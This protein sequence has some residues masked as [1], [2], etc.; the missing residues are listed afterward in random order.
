[1]KKGALIN[2]INWKL[3]KYLFWLGPMLVIMG[4]T[5]GAVIGSWGVVPSGLVLAGIAVIVA[6]LL[7]ESS[8]QPGFWR[9]RSTQVSTNAL[10]AT[11]AMLIILAMV[12]VLAVRYSA[13]LDLTENQIFTLAPQTQEVVQSLKQPVK[14]WIFSPTPNPL[15]KELLENYRRQNQQFSYE[16][17]DPQAKPGVAEKFEVQSIGEIYLEA[18]NNRKFVQTLN[19]QEQLSERK[20]TN[21]IAQV[22]NNQPEKVYFLQGH[23]ERSLDAGQ[24]AMSQAIAA[25][26]EENYTPEPLNLAQAL[27]VPEDAKV[28][29]MASP[30]RPLL[31]RERE[32]LEAYLQRQSGLLLL[33]DPQTD[34]QLNDLLSSWGVQLSDRLVTDP[35]GQ[36]AQLGPGVVIVNQYGNHPITEGFRNGISFYPLARPL[37]QTPVTGVEAAPLLIASD[38]TRAQQI[39]QNGELQSQA[40]DPKGPFYIGV[41]LSRTIEQPEAPAAAGPS[42][43]PQPSPSPA[44]DDDSKPQARLIVIGNS[45][46]ATD[47]F[48]GQQLNGDV[49]L[50][51]VSWLSQQDDQVLAIRPREATS[52]RIVLSPEQQMTVALMAM[53]FLP[54]IGFG[55]ATAVWWRRR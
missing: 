27:K 9:R 22:M 51:S 21:G 53:A 28:L 50:N 24:G 7:L 33:V 8:A 55:T 29:V 54:L 49:F 37:Q 30:Q 23:G 20:L 19:P 17:V 2:L 31:P 47:G 48:F 25:L 10:L 39:G 46:F 35:A 34:P 45:G 3:L 11:L 40:T 14:A 18:G 38:L 15:D 32:A 5:A 1:M 41:A 44:A 16:Y 6:W 36:A 42:P 4:L 13:R 52:R 43:T 26:K 12:N